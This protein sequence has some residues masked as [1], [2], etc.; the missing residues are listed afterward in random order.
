MPILLALAVVVAA[1][2]LYMATTRPCMGHHGH[3]HWRRRR[4][5]H[6]W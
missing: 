5:H 2:S 6:N 1:A 3:R 4:Q